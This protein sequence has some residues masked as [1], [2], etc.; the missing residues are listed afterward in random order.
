[1]KPKSVKC[2]RCGRKSFI[3]LGNVA[4]K[5]GRIVVFLKCKV[6]GKINR[7]HTRENKF[8]AYVVEEG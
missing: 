1:M 6:C 4:Y 3:E 7:V 5:D 2:I 8:D